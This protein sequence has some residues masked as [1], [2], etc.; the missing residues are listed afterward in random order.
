MQ[1]VAVVDW[2][3]KD[4]L[5]IPAGTQLAFSNLQVALDEEL[6]PN[7]NTFDPKRY[8]RKRE[9]IDP[10]KF[11]FASITDDSLHFGTGFHACSGR[12][13]AQDAMKL[14]FFHLLT[15]YDLK[16]PEDGQKSP[17]SIPLDFNIMPN[18]MAPLL[19]KERTV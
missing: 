18:V 3:F 19:F 10:N 17:A 13:V 6:H 15:H 7:A 2:N 5:L 12:F 9:E 1:R 8:L 14:I 4:G 16:Y 11:H